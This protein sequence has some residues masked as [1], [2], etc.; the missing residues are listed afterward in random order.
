MQAGVRREG[1]ASKASKANAQVLRSYASSKNVTHSNVVS[2]PYR[3]YS[4]AVSRPSRGY[5]ALMNPIWHWATEV[6]SRFMKAETGLCDRSGVGIGDGRRLLLQVRRWNG[7]LRES[8]C[9]G[10][11][12]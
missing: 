7:P 2:R 11:V 12:A 1:M 3:G 6:V 4:K 5:F 8:A 10:P 9:Q